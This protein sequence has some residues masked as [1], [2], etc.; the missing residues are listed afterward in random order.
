[1]EPKRHPIVHSRKFNR[2]RTETCNKKL[3]PTQQLDNK[4]TDELRERI[5]TRIQSAR[6][7]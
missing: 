7:K 4:V 5:S 3:K 6:D 2:S 1:M